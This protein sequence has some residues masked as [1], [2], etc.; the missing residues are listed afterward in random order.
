MTKCF[1][2][3][4]ANHI[5]VQKVDTLNKKTLSLTFAVILVAI[6]FTAYYI[7][8]YPFV[9][10]GKTGASSQVE[11]SLQLS[12]TLDAN[13]TNFRQGEEINLT[14]TLT[15][16]SNLTKT[17]TDVNGASIFNFEIYQSSPDNWIYMY[18]IGAYP[19]IDKTITIPPNANY[20]QTFTWDQRGLDYIHPSQEPVGTYHIIGNI[21]DNG[22]IPSLQTSR[23][24]ICI[25]YP[26]LEIAV[27]FLIALITVACIFVTLLVYIRHR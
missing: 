4:I 10:Y 11:D 25:K 14:L 15:N 7:Q 9:N 6:I 22:S 1:K 2:E 24:S 13:K 18:E 26:L 8:G 17:L 21:N 16:L 3:K 23:L 20:N 5:N 27:F 19:I 12:I